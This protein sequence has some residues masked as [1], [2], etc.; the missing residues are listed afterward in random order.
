[1]NTENM[2]PNTEV[3]GSLKEVMTDNIAAGN[4]SVRFVRF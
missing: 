2:T 1:V 3:M 4:G